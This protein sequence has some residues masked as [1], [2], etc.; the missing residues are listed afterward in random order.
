MA[1][2][3][4]TDRMLLVLDLDETLIY[5]CEERLEREPDFSAFQYHVYVRP[6]LAHFLERC[7][8]HFELAVW[9]SAS[10]DYVDAVAKRIFPDYIPLH[11]VWGRSRA[12]LRRMVTDEGYFG[13]Y[14]NHMHYRKPLARLKRLGWRLE[15]VLILD[16]TPEK[17]QQ[18]YGN[19]IYPTPWEGEPGDVEL[20]RLAHYLP[21]LRECENVRA[22]EKRNWRQHP[23][24]KELDPP[25]S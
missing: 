7:S 16:D 4:T 9:S 25:D 2:G 14:W 10:D 24:V 21:T 15:R 18:N 11:F 19:A 3:S 22:V 8:R 23:A 17:S 5:A 6:H 12:S 20:L 1:N 13:D